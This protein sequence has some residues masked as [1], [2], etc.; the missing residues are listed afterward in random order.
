MKKPFLLLIIIFVC[1]SFVFASGKLKII[2]PDDSYRAVIDGNTYDSTGNILTLSL[3]KGNHNLNVK[4]KTGDSVY[5]ENIEIVNQEI[6]VVD[7][8]SRMKTNKPN[9]PVLI[10]QNK[11]APVIKKTGLNVYLEYGLP[12]EVVLSLPWGDDAYQDPGGYGLGLSFASSLSDKIDLCFGGTYYFPR[13]FKYVISGIDGLKYS[14][15]NDPTYNYMPIYARLKFY[16]SRSYTNYSFFFGGDL[17]YSL[18]SVSGKYFEGLTVNNGTGYGFFIGLCTVDFEIEAG[19]IA[20]GS[21][22]SA[23]GDSGNVKNSYYYL[24]AGY[25]I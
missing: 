19:Y 25:N 11:Y 2:L 16:P 21:T 15:T 7:V 13:T 6:S 22:W 1:S 10:N 23:F 9:M 3:S 18:M 12:S 8:E 5:S 4:S 14:L 24:K 20:Q 17:R